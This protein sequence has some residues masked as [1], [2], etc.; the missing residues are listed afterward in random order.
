MQGSTGG[1][2]ILLPQVP[3]SDILFTQDGPV[4]RD[5]DLPVEI[6][7]PQQSAVKK[8][9]N[10][11]VILTELLLAHRARG[12]RV[13]LEGIVHHLFFFSRRI[14]AIQADGEQDNQV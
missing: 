2:G 14:T 10:H 11:A 13:V 4:L 3:F 6:V 1:H 8:S 7:V 12:R 5:Q 9:G